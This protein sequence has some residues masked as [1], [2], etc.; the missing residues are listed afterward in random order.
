MNNNLKKNTKDELIDEILKLR[1]KN[2]DLENENNDLENENKDLKWKL[3]TNMT[4]SWNSSSTERFKK[5][6]VI[7][8]RATWKKTR[9]WKKGHNWSNLKRN[10]NV[11]EVV[12][13]TPDKCEKCW[14]TLLN[15]LSKI[16]RSVTRQIID[17]KKLKTK[18][19]DYIITDIKCYNCWFVNNAIVPEGITN[20]NNSEFYTVDVFAE[21]RYSGN[22]LAVFVDAGDL[23]LT[24]TSG[25]NA[26]GDTAIVF[27]DAGDFV[28]FKRAEMWTGQLD[29]WQESLRVTETAVEQ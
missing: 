27:D 26:D 10:E 11:D 23:T 20:V 12:D 28:L 17:L 6:K 8:L 9:W 13:L 21:E 19:T 1:E 16:V 14:V 18:V 29:K 2:K 7:N 22:Q 5:K 15:G 24:V 4:N 3:N 25:Y